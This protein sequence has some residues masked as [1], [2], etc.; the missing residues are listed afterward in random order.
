MAVKKQTFMNGVL[1]VMFSQIL[2]KI[3]GFVY[4]IILTNIPSFS[5]EGNSYYGSAYQVYTLILA[6]ATMGIPILYQNWY[7]RKWL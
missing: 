5:D 2:I 3:F 6:I 4:R 1:V 7:P